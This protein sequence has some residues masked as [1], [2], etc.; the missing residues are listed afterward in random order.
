MKEERNQK[1][2]NGHF[3]NSRIE[4][5]AR[6]CS[7]VSTIF[8]KFNEIMRKASRRDNRAFKVPDWMSISHFS[9]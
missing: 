3:S 4:L 1:N 5:I 7:E 9:I 6:N 8:T 2:Q